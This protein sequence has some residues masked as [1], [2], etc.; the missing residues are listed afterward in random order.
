MVVCFRGGGGGPEKNRSLPPS[1]PPPPS[2]SYTSLLFCDQMWRLLLR[3]R[4]LV[5]CCTR[6]ATGCACRWELATT[7]GGT[8]TNFGLAKSKKKSSAR[9]QQTQSCAGRHSGIQRAD[10]TGLEFKTGH[11]GVWS[12]KPLSRGKMPEL[13]PR[14]PMAGFRINNW[15]S[16]AALA[17]WGLL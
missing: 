15:G 4:L 11:I 12:V 3:R 5:S 7:F 8:T 9:L 2:Y 1:P 10:G 17:P 14:G 13:G 16:V 6:E